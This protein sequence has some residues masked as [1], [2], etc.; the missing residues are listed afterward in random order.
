VVFSARM[1]V[2][3][4]AALLVAAAGLPLLAQTYYVQFATKI[5]LLGMLAMALNLVVGLGGLVSMCHAAFYGLAGY[6]LALA[7]PKYDPASLWLTLP[8]AVGASAIAA[9]AIGALSLR[10]RGIYFIM[11]TL[12]FGEMMFY[13]L[14]DTKFAGGSDGTFINLKPEMSIFGVSLLDLDN[15]RV[16]YWLVLALTLATIAFLAIVSRSS[17]GR[18]L[19]AS[20]DNERR[21]RS[22][23][24]PI[25]RIRLTA[26]V[27]SGALAGLAGYF[28][29]AQFGYVA[30]DMLGWRLSATA[31]MM[32]VLGGMRGIAGPLI[33]AV[34]LFCFE[35]L[36]QGWSE[37]WKLAEGLILIA[38]VL[39]FPG[40]A[41][42]LLDRIVKPHDKAADPGGPV[43]EAPRG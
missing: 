36:L 12:A 33:G 27:I 37:H 23:G 7:A 6:V 20:R 14:H 30:P 24:F 8:L 15:A 35:E 1:R 13:F 22:L 2:L 32:V 28:S 3:A 10:T 26:F 16:F 25:Y 39:A 9:L 4:A 41:Y 29:A 18:A 21:A 5:L 40:G 19:A 34:L 38:I 31:L 17:F 43:A 42:D 11:V